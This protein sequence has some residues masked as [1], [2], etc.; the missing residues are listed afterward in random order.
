VIAGDYTTGPG[1]SEY[2]PGHLKRNKSQSASKF[3]PGHRTTTTTTGMRIKAQKYESG[4]LELPAWGTHD[5]LCDF[6]AIICDDIS[7][8]ESDRV[9][10]GAL[11]ERVAHLPDNDFEGLERRDHVSL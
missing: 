10:S 3:T 4:M 5:N 8:F 11:F 2:A 9:H 6:K 1:A 7:E